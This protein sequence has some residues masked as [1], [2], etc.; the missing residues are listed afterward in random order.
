[1][2]APEEERQAWGQALLRTL[3]FGDVIA[4]ASAFVG[5]VGSYTIIQER[6]TRLE[7]RLIGWQSA[8]TARD[9]RQDESARDLKLDTKEALN[10]IKEA[11]QEINRKLDRRLGP[12]Q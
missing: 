6:L 12:R 8:Q 4:I 9:L 11:V 5:I 10:E 7:E 2:S 3:N 1:M